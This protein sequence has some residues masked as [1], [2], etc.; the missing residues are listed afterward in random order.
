M[1]ETKP[2]AI[3]PSATNLAASVAEAFRGKHISLRAAF[4]LRA[5]IER[6]IRMHAHRT[7]IYGPDERARIATLTNLSDEQVRS[8]ITEAGGMCVTAEYLP[9]A[10]STTLDDVPEASDLLTDAVTTTRIESE[11]RMLLHASRDAMR[12]RH[13]NTRKVPFHSSDGYYAEAFGVMRGLQI[14]GYGYLGTSSQTD[15]IRNLRAWFHRIEQSVLE[16]EGFDGDNR[17]EY[18]FARYGKDDSR[19]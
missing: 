14:A 11:I 12:N 4:K 6:A 8:V 18:C 2:I 5:M 1:L 10:W 3:A 17:C 13:E 9:Q 19:P 7:L 16:D 15:D